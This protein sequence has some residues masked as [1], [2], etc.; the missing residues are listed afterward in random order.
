MIL[1]DWGLKYREA[2]DKTNDKQFILFNDEGDWM[3]YPP[4]MPVLVSCLPL[5][6]DISTRRW[7]GG[8]GGGCEGTPQQLPILNFWVPLGPMS[9]MIKP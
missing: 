1:K 6:S 9:A 8:G 5:L 2:A 4:C 7:G 3:L